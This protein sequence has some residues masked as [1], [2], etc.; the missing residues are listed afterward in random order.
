MSAIAKASFVPTLRELHLNR[1]TITDAI[2]KQLA[3][4]GLPALEVLHV[5]YAEASVNALDPIV[6]AAPKLRLVEVPGAVRI[7]K[8]W[9]KRGRQIL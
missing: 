7:P 4:H 5:K 2:G 9:V 6:R 3:A 1:A 8:H